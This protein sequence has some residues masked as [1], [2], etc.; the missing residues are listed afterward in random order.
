VNL[1]LGLADLPAMQSFQGLREEPV[2]SRCGVAQPS[3]NAMG[4][5]GQTRLGEV[6]KVSG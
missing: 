3:G 4:A 2:A 1:A 6:A 5:A